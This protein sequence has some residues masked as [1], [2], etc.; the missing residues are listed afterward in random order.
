[1]ISYPVD[2][3]L[4]LIIRK[5][6]LRYPNLR[7]MLTCPTDTRPICAFYGL[8]TAFLR[9]CRGIGHGGVGGYL[10]GLV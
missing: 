10:G 1:M 9:D 5:F 7:Y 4:L 6:V 8:K 3:I 2:L